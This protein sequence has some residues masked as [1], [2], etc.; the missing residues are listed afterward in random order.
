MKIGLLG[1]IHGNHRALQAVLS[2]AVS[3]KLEVL[4]FT[5]DLV[6]YYDSPLAVLNMLKLWKCYMVRGNHEEMLNQ[7]RVDSDFLVEA[8]AKYGTGLRSA[9]KQLSKEQIDE[10]CNLPHPLSLEI[11]SCKILLC[12]GS[13]WDINQYVYPDS[14]QKLLAK[15]AIKNYELVVLGHTHYPMIHKIGNTLIVNPGSVGQPRDSRP[16]AHWAIYDTKL[17]SVEFFNENYDCSGLIEE[18]RA[19]SPELPYLAEILM[20]K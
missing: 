13:P 5:G 9:I 15:C 7:A 10:L 2:A 12:H 11:D 4:L 19:N 1:D 18:C 17:K 8:D 16:G 20:R 14:P 3:L 6:G